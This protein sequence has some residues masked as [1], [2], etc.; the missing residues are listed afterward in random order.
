M[1]Y[2]A[3]VIVST[4]YVGRNFT[5]SF[6]KKAFVKFFDGFVN[7][8]FGGGYTSLHITVRH[9]IEFEVAIYGFLP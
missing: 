6:W 9:S 5:K 8:F 1:H 7:I 3:I 2:V 4:Q